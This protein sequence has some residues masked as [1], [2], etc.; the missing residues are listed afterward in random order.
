MRRLIILTLALFVLAPPGQAL[1]H[2]LGQSQ[3]LPLPFWL[4][5]FAAAAVVL[6]SQKDSS[7]L[8]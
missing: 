8:A 1:A 4:Y 6:I 5:L 2:G 3:N 7:V